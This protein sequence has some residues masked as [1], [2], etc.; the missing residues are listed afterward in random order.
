MLDTKARLFTPLPAVSLEQ[1]VAADHFYR[2]LDRVLDLSFVRKLVQD[3]YAPNMGRPSVDHV[4]FFK[5]QWVMFFD[6][7]RSE[8]QLLRLAADRLRVRWTSSS[9]CICCYWWRLSRIQYSAAPH[10]FAA[11]MPEDGAFVLR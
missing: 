2:L 7:I 9:R 10:S 11:M 8:H 3:R 6:G 4:V 5:L 1:L